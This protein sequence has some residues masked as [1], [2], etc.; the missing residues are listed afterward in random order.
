MNGK[1]TQRVKSRELELDGEKEYGLHCMWYSLLVVEVV[2][3]GG[4][5][6]EGL[7]PAGEA[8]QVLKAGGV[9]GPVVRRERFKK[10][11]FLP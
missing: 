2:V 10:A 3:G 1:I 7:D 8:R 11:T 9:A 6:V 5:E 4:L